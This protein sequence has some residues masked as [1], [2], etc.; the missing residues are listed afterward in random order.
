[1]AG[2]TLMKSDRTCQ[3]SKL[4]ITRIYGQSIFSLLDGT[5]QSGNV[6]SWTIKIVYQLGMYASE[7]KGLSA[8]TEE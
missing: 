2:A 8:C 5:T 4:K 1:M 3:S 7:R 6:A